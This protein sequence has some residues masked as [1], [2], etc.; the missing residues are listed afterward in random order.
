MSILTIKYELHCRVLH[1]DKSNDW[2][3]VCYNNNSDEEITSNIIIGVN[4]GEL[5]ALNLS[6]TSLIVLAHQLPQWPFVLP[7]FA[8]NI[9][10]P[11]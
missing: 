7:L 8:R 5:K 3:V 11:P 1:E 6:R 4:R 10:V 9:S 2:S